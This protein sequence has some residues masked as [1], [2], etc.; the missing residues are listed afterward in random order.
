MH[1]SVLLL[2]YNLFLASGASNTRVPVTPATS[3][4]P[5]YSNN[6]IFKSTL[7]EPHNTYRTSH[8]ASSLLWH[9][10]RATSADRHAQP[11]D[12]THSKNIPFG[13]NLAAG[14]PNTTAAVEVWGNEREHYD[15]SDAEFD[16]ETGH[17]T[18]VVWKTTTDVG[19]GAAWCDGENGTPGWYLVC[20]YFPAGNVN[21]VFKDNV[22]EEM[23]ENGGG[24]TKMV[25]KW[26]ST[27]GVIIA[28]VSGGW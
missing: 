17:F 7:L 12:F 19:C 26:W 28:I 23:T 5:S 3:S 8:N 14:Y 20:Q 27:T 6:D 4:T 18:Q 10:T 9:S 1:V 24:R 2:L 22:E 25:G 11:C 15:F 16:D 13:E 21:G